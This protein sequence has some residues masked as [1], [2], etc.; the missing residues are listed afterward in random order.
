MEGKNETKASKG[1]QGVCFFE[2]YSESNFKLVSLLAFL[3]FLQAGGVD[4]NR[5]LTQFLF[6]TSCIY[7]GATRSL[8]EY[9]FKP[10]PNDKQQGQQR[11]QAESLLDRVTR[12]ASM[13]ALCTLS[14][15][16]IYCSIKFELSFLKVAMQ[17]YILFLCFLVIS[18]Y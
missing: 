4:I 1:K 16:A 10:A 5:H 3:M 8:K 13:P 2:A 14:L 6:T 11:A 7:L 12:L 17:A 15:L 18:T 9:N